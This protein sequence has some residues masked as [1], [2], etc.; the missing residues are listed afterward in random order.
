VIEHGLS[1][2]VTG[3]GADT[4]SADDSHLVIRAFRAASDHLGLRPPGISLRC[5]NSIPHARGLGSSAAAIVAGVASAY[6]LADKPLDEHALRIAAGFE[7]HADNAAASMYGGLALAWREQDTGFHALRVEPHP[8]LRPVVL[9]PTTQSATAVTR[10]L[11]PERVPHT[12]A[13]FAAGRCALAVQAITSRPDLLLP[14][15]ADVLHQD[16]RESAW[17][18]TMRLVRELRSLGA[19]AAVSGAGPTVIVFT[20]DGALPAGVDTHGFEVH[21]LAVDRGGVQVEPLR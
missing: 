12:D 2:E 11:L 8:A 13:A 17:P 3:E 21:W 6:G 19:A 4:V 14:A 16:Y 18:A 10:G 7:G 20:T 5:V 15:T 9:V 1:I